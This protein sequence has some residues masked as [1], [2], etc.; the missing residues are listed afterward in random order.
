MAVESADSMCPGIG[1]GGP[2][3]GA[4]RALGA[5]APGAAELPSDIPPATIPPATHSATTSTPR[6]PR[7]LTRLFKRR[8]TPRTIALAAI[9]LARQQAAVKSNSS[10]RTYGFMLLNRS[11]PCCGV[12]ELQPDVEDVLPDLQMLVGLRR[13]A[14]PVAL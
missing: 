11:H 8:I 14:L 4:G 6:L 5:F 7:A 9:A 3:A 12:N 1:D 10:L 13:G 2:G